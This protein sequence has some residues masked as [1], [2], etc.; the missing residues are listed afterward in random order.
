MSY[1]RNDKVNGKHD[2]VTSS[3]PCVSRSGVNV[4]TWNVYL[5]YDGLEENHETFTVILKGPKN[6]V[7]GQR[8]SANVEIIDPRGGMH[9]VHSSRLLL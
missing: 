8:N 1:F 6:A 2:D 7:L 3:F 4:K 9:T 5:K